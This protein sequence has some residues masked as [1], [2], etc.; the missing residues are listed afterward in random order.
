MPKVLRPQTHDEWLQL[1]GTGIGSSEVGTI[2]GLNRWETP[3]QLWRRKLGLDAPV[4]ENNA[5]LMGHLLED[6]VAKRWEIE[7]GMSVIKR[8][9]VDFIVVDDSRDYL[10]VSPDRTYYLPECAHNNANKGIV[11]C[12]STAMYITEDDVPLTW[13]TQLQYQMGVCGYK[14]GWLAWLTQGREFGCKHYEFDADYYQ[15]IVT[16]VDRFYNYNI[17]QQVEPESISVDDVLTKNPRAAEGKTLT[18]N[19]NLLLAVDTL[20]A[21]NERLKADKAEKDKLEE[22]I[23]LALA[24]AESLIDGS[25]GKPLLTWKNN[26]DGSRFNEKLFAQEHPELYQQYLEVRQGARVLRLK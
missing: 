18:A 5:M 3:L 7:T 23:K 24:D 8:S 2:L 13:F 14:H 19:D 1:R 10:R 26:K 17:L 22:Q 20:K 6:A 25:T 16:E 9:A 4:P 11:E 15:Y 12:K 21:V